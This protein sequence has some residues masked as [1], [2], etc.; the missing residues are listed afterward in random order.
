MHDLPIDLPRIAAFRA[1]GGRERELTL[2][3]L[4]QAGDATSQ[5]GLNWRQSAAN[6]HRRL[7]QIAVLF[8]LPP[9]G[10]ALAIPPKRNAGSIGI[11]IGIGLLIVYNQISQATERASAT[12]HLDPIAAQWLP[13]TG[14]ALLSAWL[15]YRLAYRVESNPAAQ[16]E[17]LASRLARTIGSALRRLRPR[18]ATW[19][20]G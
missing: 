19:I 6:L 16:I 20:E 15:F 9:L 7:I 17:R 1:R 5:P 12:G 13:F 14:F 4:W 3:E 10:L 8:L 2:P 11:F 18:R